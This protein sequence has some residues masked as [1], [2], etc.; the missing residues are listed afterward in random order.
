M[1]TP[2]MRKATL[3]LLLLTGSVPLP[4]GLA[5]GTALPAAA[6]NTATSEEP[7]KAFLTTAIRDGLA[8]VELGKLGAQ[9]GSAA[10]VKQF[11]EQMVKD[12]QAANEKL[13]AAAQGAT[14]SP[15][16]KAQTALGKLKGMS[17]AKFD[18][19]FMRQMVED[20]VKAVALFQREAKS[21]K[22][23]QVRNLAGEILPT[24]EEHLRMARSTDKQIGAKS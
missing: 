5:I 22:D 11:A 18:Q 10:E 8:E 21:G 6:A 1:E 17:G 20:H 13:M 9:Q 24:L 2:A 12:H 16:K 15:D 7:D 19:A 23:E 14:P 3:A 4:L